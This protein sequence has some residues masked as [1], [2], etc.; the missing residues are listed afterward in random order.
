MRY[1]MM[2]LFLTRR[3]EG[4]LFAHLPPHEERGAYLKR[5]FGSEIRFTH[6]KKSYVYESFPSPDQGMHLIGVIGREHTTIIGAP[7]EERFRRHGVADWETA[8][9]FIDPAGEGEGQKIAMQ[10]VTVVGNPLGVFR[11][12]AEQLNAA[13]G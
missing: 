8:N 3:E 7:P 12:L 6:R 4:T 10:H 9:V 1:W 2:R 5:V 11:S 13:P